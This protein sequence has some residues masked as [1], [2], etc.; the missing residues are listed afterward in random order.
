MPHHTQPAHDKGDTSQSKASVYLAE[1]K[2]EIIT[3]WTVENLTKSWMAGE[4]RRNPEY[5]RGARWSPPQKQSLIDSVFRDY[6]IPPIFLQEITTIGLKGPSSVYEI[7]DGQQRILALSEFAGDAFETLD[8][9]D[10]KL[11]LPNS[12]R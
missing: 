5:Q 3:T 6:P 12:L 11:R 8:A 10:R 1:M 4:M 7:V 9:K 2:F